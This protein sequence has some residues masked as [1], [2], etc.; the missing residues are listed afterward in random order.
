MVEILDVLAA[1]V[2]PPV[3]V[4]LVSFALGLTLRAPQFKRILER[5]KA[6]L[7]GLT[8]QLILLPVCAIL[9]DLI[10]PIGPAVALGLA[11][12]AFCPGGAT[13]NAVVFAVGGRSALSVSLTICV[14]FITMVTIPLALPPVMNL[15]GGELAQAVPTHVIF[16]GILSGVGLPIGTGMVLAH[17]FPAWADK[18][19][20]R[21]KPMAVLLI[22]LA[23]AA[24]FYNAHEYMTQD[25][26]PIIGSATLLSFLVVGGGFLMGRLVNLKLKD[27]LTISVEIGLQ[28]VP[29]AFYLATT[30]LGRPDLAV[31][32]ILYGA[33]NYA[34]VFAL[35]GYI[36]LTR[37]RFRK[38]PK[39]RLASAE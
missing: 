28:N 26:A 38:A 16:A 12:M 9:L 6:L 39:P 11:M 18:V 8:G 10:L 3:A 23:V 30:I 22:G 31:V 15:F 27:R 33:I 1:K 20:A 32:A 24:G 21:F 17:F 2:V 35:I 7:T 5:P 29:F 19:I 36:R 4:L 37:R 25:M 34:M 13:S 14:S